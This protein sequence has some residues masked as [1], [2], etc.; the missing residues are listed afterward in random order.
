M[1]AQVH[2]RNTV[3]YNKLNS[4]NVWLCDSLMRTLY[5]TSYIR[6]VKLVLPVFHSPCQGVRFCVLTLTTVIPIKSTPVCGHERPLSQTRN[7]SGERCWAG[8]IKAQSSSRNQDNLL[9]A[10]SVTNRTLTSQC[11]SGSVLDTDWSRTWDLG[12]CRFWAV[13]AWGAATTAEGTSVKCGVNWAKQT[14]W[15][16]L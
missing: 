16:T 13:T 15:I 3:Q 2:H 6:S 8:P 11:I 14:K 5:R 9:Q 10:R 1:E 4:G 7:D 12:S